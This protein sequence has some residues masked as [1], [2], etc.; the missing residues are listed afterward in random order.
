[1]SNDEYLISQRENLNNRLWNC[2]NPYQGNARK[3]L[4]V[5]SAGMLRSA[6][7]ANVLHKELGHNTRA[8]GL[9]RGHALI[10][11]DAVLIEWADE[12]VVMDKQM[13]ESVSFLCTTPKSLK[14]PIINLDIPDNYNYMDTKLQNLIIERYMKQ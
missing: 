8:V 14:T 5:C 13:K 9:D 12:I 1:M 2:A 10:V 4:C 3:V 7:A 6:T 11:I